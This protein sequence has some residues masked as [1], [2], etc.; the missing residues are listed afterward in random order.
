MHATGGRTMREKVEE[1]VKFSQKTKQR[2]PRG[3]GG[4]ESSGGDSDESVCAELR[5]FLD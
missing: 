3:A 4:A 5:E 2:R 1:L